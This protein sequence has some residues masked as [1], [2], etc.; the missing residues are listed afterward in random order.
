MEQILQ[1]VV[2]QIEQMKLMYLQIGDL[3][4]EVYIKVLY[5]I[6]EI[7]VA[8]VIMASLGIWMSLQ[9]GMMTN[10]QM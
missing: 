3:E 7:E 1:Y 9:Y 5:N 10:L 8:V 6:L 2:L 4:Q